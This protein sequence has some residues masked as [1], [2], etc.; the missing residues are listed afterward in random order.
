[1]SKKRELAPY[2]FIAPHL[3]LFVLFFLI[4]AVVGI[5]VSFTK[6]DIY[7]APQWVGFKNYY[8]ILV[9]S[10]SVFYEQF[11]N[12]LRNTFIFSVL[13]IPFCIAIPLLFAVLLNT[14]PKGYKFFQS[15]FY[16]PGLLSI[17]AV[18]LAWNFMFNKT[19]GLVNNMTN[20]D[21][22]WGSTFPWYW[23]A[24]IIITVWWCIGSNMVIYQA[25]I[26]SVPTDYY[27]AAAIDGAGALKQF[28][29]ITLPSIK[30]QILYTLVMTTIAQFN[31]YGQPLMFNNG[32]PNGANRVLLMYIRELGFGQGSSLA[33]MASAMA[34]ML[35]IC[36][37]FICILQA[38]LSRDEDEVL[39]KKQ[40]KKN[41]KLNKA[42]IK[43]AGATYNLSEGGK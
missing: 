9:N 39:A 36:I 19:F 41:K 22:N 17:S 38:V 33:G 28:F 29:K 8:E 43:T 11:W 6:W 31:I 26:A 24:L 12:G 21:I 16:V 34:A 27:E 14:K 4:P 3:I 37:L 23:I 15:V 35:G 1:M 20:L 18:M 25:A 30:S 10:E 42:K 7:S 13:T 2:S 32:G 5:Y 40:R